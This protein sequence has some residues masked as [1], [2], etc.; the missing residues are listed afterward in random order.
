M[1]RRRSAKS[2]LAS[3]A[4]ISMAF[5]GSTFLDADP[6]SGAESTTCDDCFRLRIGRP[7]I[8]RGPAGDE[9]DN[10]VPIIKL[11]SGG[12]RAFTANI[13]SYRIDAPAPWSLGW[14]RS[15]V[16]AP[17]I[18]G[19][20]AECGRWINSVHK[21]NGLLF[22]FVH[23]ERACDHGS[24]SQVDKS[25]AV[26]TSADEGLTWAG[27]GSFLVGRD[28]PRAGEPT[29]EGDCSVVNGHDG[30][31]Y[32]YCLRHSDWRTIVARAPAD[33]PYPGQ[34]RKWYAKRWTEAGQGGRAQPLG[35]LGLASAY[36]TS[37][38]R[39]ILVGARA[40]KGLTLSVSKDKVRF[41]T[42]S[43]PL[44]AGEEGSWDRPSDNDLHAYVSLVDPD[45]GGNDLGDVFG[46]LTVYVA[47]GEGF[48]RR[49]LVYRDVALQKLAWKPW[50]QVGVALSRFRQPATGRLRASTAPVVDGGY[51]EEKFLGYML[52]AKP[53]G[54]A[55]VEITECAST[56]GEGDLLLARG[57]GCGS[58][59]Y[60][61]VRTSGWLL[62]SA[63]AG[64]L[65]VYSCLNAQARY[66]FASNDPTCDGLGGKERLLGH[67]LAR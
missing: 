63:K 44:V 19:S 45:R 65:P 30:F 20:S 31:L 53:S 6:S 25:M 51:Q 58:A 62:A 49:R 56:A 8:A 28:P 37:L 15:A 43:A 17:G 27:R 21:V 11:G 35:D 29:G 7:L 57:S 42:L 67:A 3:L 5:V 61:K 60:R 54:R 26:F 39:V 14:K 36:L 38:K 59:A 4:L 52:T 46:L 18:Q 9:M 50:D 64:T 41:K 10:M 16:L 23:E 66:H 48:D 34:W 40:G 32:A 55:S 33:N 1:N 47:P 13:T 24:G 22:G 2:A 12:F